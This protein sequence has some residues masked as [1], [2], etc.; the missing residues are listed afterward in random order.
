MPCSM[1]PS[2]EKKQSTEWDFLSAHFFIGTAWHDRIMQLGMKTPIVVVIYRA[3][4]DAKYI[5]LAFLHLLWRSLH[6]FLKMDS[7]F[8]EQELL[9]R[10]RPSD[11]CRARLAILQ[12]KAHAGSS[13]ST[14]KHH[15]RF[16]IYNSST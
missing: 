9:Q 10:R 7:Y 13:T 4:S 8:I 14:I 1:I 2:D 5:S 11:S 6:E 16:A 12:H 15:Q 3:K